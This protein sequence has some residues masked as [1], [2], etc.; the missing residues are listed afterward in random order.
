[1]EH[2]IFRLWKIMARSGDNNFPVYADNKNDSWFPKDKT[3][4][5]EFKYP[6]SDMG[7]IRGIFEYCD[8]GI[9]LIQTVENLKA[10]ADKLKNEKQNFA[11]KAGRAE[12]SSR[13]LREKRMLRIRLSP[14]AETNA[15]RFSQ[16]GEIS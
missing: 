6:I 1:M 11:R 7:D 5:G 12:S 9:K 14:A 13:G 8:R 10:G 2:S 3:A 4:C 16:N 15:V